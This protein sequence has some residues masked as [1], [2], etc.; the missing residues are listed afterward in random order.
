M[1]GIID[2]V[3]F[4]ITRDNAL[5]GG[6]ITLSLDREDVTCQSTRDT[7]RVVDKAMGVNSLILARTVIHSQNFLDGLLGESNVGLKEY[8]ILIV[9]LDVLTGAASTT[10]SAAREEVGRSANLGGMI[11]L[12][13]KDI[14]A[15]RGRVDNAR[16]EANTRLVE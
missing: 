14:D 5:T 16:K 9:P 15:M 2:F 13:R 6:G 1:Q 7:Q 4:V 12:R 3:P 11:S 8:P 10:R